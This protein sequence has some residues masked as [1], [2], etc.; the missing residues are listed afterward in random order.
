MTD[1]RPGELRPFVLDDTQ[2][3]TCLTRKYE[4]RKPYMPADPRRLRAA[5]PGVITS[6]S[7]QPGQK[8]R[9]GE[10][11]LALEAMKMRNEITAPRDGEIMSVCVQKGQ[12]VTKGQV[13]IEFVD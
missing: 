12:M 6:V 7:I 4:N 10:G 13:L 2:Y 3:S 5:I 9:R 11:L 1:P 8:V